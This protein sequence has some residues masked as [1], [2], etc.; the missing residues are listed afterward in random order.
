LIHLVDGLLN[1]FLE[2]PPGIVTILT[3]YRN[4]FGKQGVAV[5]SM[6]S[7]STTLFESGFHEISDEIANLSGHRSVLDFGLPW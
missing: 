1:R 7:F 3:R 6:A 5:V 2:M 4:H